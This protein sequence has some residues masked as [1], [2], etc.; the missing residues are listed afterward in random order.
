MFDNGSE[1]KRDFIPLLKQFDIKPKL[2]TIKNPQSNAPVERIHQVVANML[3]TQ[4]LKNKVLDHIDPW[5]EILASIAW[6]VRSAHHNVLGATPAQLVFNRDMLFNLKTVVDWKQISARK[7]KQVDMDNLR[8]N[9]KRIDH[10]Y[11]VDDKVYIARDGIYRKL[12][13][14]RLGPYKVT[15]I[16]MNGTVRVQRGAINE[17]INIRRLSPHFSSFP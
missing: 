15:K 8:E 1:F 2:T 12:E 7:Q 5:G 3:R 10:D 6:A 17:R 11:Q 14:P 13:G 4:D 9:S 16:H